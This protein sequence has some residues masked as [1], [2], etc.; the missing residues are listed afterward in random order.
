MAYGNDGSS[1]P[2]TYHFS[3]KQRKV[4]VYF[5]MLQLT[6]TGGNWAPTSN[7]RFDRYE[8]DDN[9]IAARS[10]GLAETQT[11]T[12]HVSGRTD[13]IDWLRFNYPSTGSF[14]SYVITVTQ[15][16]PSA[17]NPVNIYLRQSTGVAGARLTGVTTSTSGNATTYAIP[18]GLLTRGADYLIELLRNSSGYQEYDI[19]LKQN[20]VTPTTISGPALACNTNGTYS[21]NP[22]PMAGT[23]IAWSNSANLTYVSGQGTASYTV[24]GNAA[25][26][27][28]VS[29][30]LTT[31]CG[32]APAITKNI[33][34]AGGGYGSSDYPIT[35]P[36][37]ACRNQSV[38][39]NTVTLPNATNYTW[40]W[41][42]SWIYTGGQGTPYLSLNTGSS[43]ASGAVTV[44]VANNCDAGGSPA[45][46]F[47]SVSSCG[48]F[49]A[50]SVFPNPTSEEINISLDEYDSLGRKTDQIPK[51]V[52]FEVTL[53]DRLQRQLAHIQAKER[54]VKLTVKDLP[55]DIYYLSLWYKEA[56]IQRQILIKRK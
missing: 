48:G 23:G 42:S 8:P 4:I 27:G 37:S 55:D 38:Y 47:T 41:P 44:R 52:S 9:S 24:R 21:L 33:S 1:T 29:A 36:S 16:T 14:G 7:N 20:G 30:I 26:S 17:L 51:D 18:C 2:C 5:S 45:T 43:G 10:I 11:H 13:N 25:G 34:V 28:Y 31:S 50:L 15:T 6:V 53:Y 32:A 56:I 40:T 39:Y 46:L 19:E 49:A 22:V 3:D 12:F 54:V 35:G